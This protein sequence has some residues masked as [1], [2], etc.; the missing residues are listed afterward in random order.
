MSLI[1]ELRSGGPRLL[2]HLGDPRGEMADVGVDSRPVLGAAALSPAD[3]AYQVEAAVDRGAAGERPAAV[4][5]ARVRAAVRVARAQHPEGGML[6]QIRARMQTEWLHHK[7]VTSS[8]LSWL[9]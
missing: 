4:T 3:H 8:L 6:V 7:N 1:S 2:G 5:A 9:I